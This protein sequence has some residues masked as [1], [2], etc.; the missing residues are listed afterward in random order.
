MADTQE[1]APAPSPAVAEEAQGNTEERL[2]DLEEWIKGKIESLGSNAKVV[3]VGAVLSPIGLLVLGNW[4]E[5]QWLQMLGVM[6]SFVITMSHIIFGPAPIWIATLIFP[7]TREGAKFALTNA[8]LAILFWQCIVAIFALLFDTHLW[9][10]QNLL[11]L[12]IL[13]ILLAVGTPLRPGKGGFGFFIEGFYTIAEFMFLAMMVYGIDFVSGLGLRDKIQENFFQQLLNVFVFL[14]DGFQ[15]WQFDLYPFLGSGIAILIALFA[16]GI[17]RKN[18]TRR[19]GE[20]GADV[21]EAPAA[22]P[23]KETS[24]DSG[25]SFVKKFVR[26]P[27]GISVFLLIAAFLAVYFVDDAAFTM[28]TG[29]TSMLGIL[30]LVSLVFV[31]TR[32][33]A[34]WL[35]CFLI[36][37]SMY[38]ASS[39]AVL[40]EMPPDVAAKIRKGRT[41]VMAAADSL[42]TKA[43]DRLSSGSGS[44]SAPTAPAASTAETV[45]LNLRSAKVCT[46]VALKSGRDVHFLF[47]ESGKRLSRGDTV[48]RTDNG[49]RILIGI[50]TSSGLYGKRTYALNRGDS[51]AV[52]TDGELVIWVNKDSRKRQSTAAR[53]S[54]E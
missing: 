5:W 12:M 47:A 24:V 33:S 50:R 29:S 48:T 42:L 18:V 4:L 13:S 7:Q 32:S 54:I 27:S 40:S 30:A 46:L 51:F 26:K 28:L 8:V 3:Y 53:F 20:N 14:I 23:A 9:P 37:G 19:M 22:K 11:V 43:Q 35:M 44:G 49:G 41:A 10:F 34:L 36:L 31:F 38:V 2:S 52:P 45:S 39:S 6:L 16:A 1:N 17:F 21:A 25:S 15:G